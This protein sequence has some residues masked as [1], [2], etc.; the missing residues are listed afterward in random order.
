MTKKLLSLAICCFTAMSLF[1]QDYNEEQTNRA[2]F[3]KRWYNYE[4][5][6]GAKIFEDYD[7]KYLI[8]VLSLEKGRYKSQRDMF[9]VAQVKALRQASEYVNGVTT[10][11]ETITRST[12]TT[13]AGGVKKGGEVSV[14][15]ID[16]LRS[17]GFVQG[18]ELLV[19]FT[20][21][22]DETLMVF[23]YSRKIIPEP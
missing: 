6:E 23:I 14:E 16:R 2:N 9:R 17:I 8:S 21:P 5:F 18:M 15:T 20:P 11:S 3:L 4:K 12:E 19:N 13:D 22:N 1:A 7:N 10:S